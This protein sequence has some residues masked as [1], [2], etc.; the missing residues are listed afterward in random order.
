MG[1]FK[2]G[3]I[4]LIGVTLLGVCLDILLN[5]RGSGKSGLVTSIFFLAGIA[6]FVVL[7]IVE[8]MRARGGR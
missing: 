8:A 1:I 4:V 2:S 7:T 6:A 5:P 3:F